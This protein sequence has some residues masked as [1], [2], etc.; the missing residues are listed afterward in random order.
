MITNLLRPSLLLLILASVFFSPSCDDSGNPATT[1]DGAD[2]TLSIGGLLS[3]TGGNWNSLG[4]A[5]KAAMEVA[6]DEINSYFASVNSGIAVT[7]NVADTRLDTGIAVTKAGDLI[8]S[9]VNAIVGPQSSAELRAVR[10]AVALS[11]VLMVSQGSTASSLSLAGDNVFRF[12]PDDRLE[13]AAT[14]ALMIADSVHAIVPMC[15]ADAGNIGLFQS[16]TA[17]LLQ[18]GGTFSAGVEYGTETLDYSAVVQAAKAQAVQLVNLYGASR[19]G[20]YLAAFDEAAEILKRA[21]GDPVLSTLKWYGGDG[22]VLSTTLTGDEAAASFASSVTFACPTYG[23]ED[24]ASDRWQPV[25]LEIKS[26]TGVDPDAFALAAYDAVWVLAL[27]FQSTG[28]SDD[29]SLL[30]NAFLKTADQYYGATGW[31]ALNEAGDRKNG[32]YDFWCIK[33]AGGQYAWA[34]TAS[35]NSLSGTIM[36]Y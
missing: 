35:Y 32:N 36:R 7:L 23:L 21:A 25:V 28:G 8:T 4:I 30:R 20:F 5:S 29:I 6:R 33:N 34:K 14:A 26:R 1:P 9:G 22:T 27:A 10:S 19:T 12:C 2:K 15:R 31:T 3:L 11:K 18:R 24:A 13:G 17:A 16:T